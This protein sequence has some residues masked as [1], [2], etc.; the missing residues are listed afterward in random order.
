VD[1][2]QEFSLSVASAVQLIR[3]PDVFLMKDKLKSALQF[4]SVQRGAF[5]KIDDFIASSLASF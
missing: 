2:V 1:H 4:F 3:I 5:A